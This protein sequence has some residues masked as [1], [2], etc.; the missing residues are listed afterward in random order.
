MLERPPLAGTGTLHAG[1]FRRSSCCLY[2]RV[3]PAAG[4][5]GDCCFTRPPRRS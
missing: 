4:V 1:G 2:Y 3:G 5:C